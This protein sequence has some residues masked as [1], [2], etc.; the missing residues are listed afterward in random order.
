MILFTAESFMR[1]GDA[2]TSHSYTKTPD[3]KGLRGMIR[4]AALS[5]GFPWNNLCFDALT[6]TD[7]VLLT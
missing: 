1:L 2:T 7:M 6:L 3:V 5:G 4:I